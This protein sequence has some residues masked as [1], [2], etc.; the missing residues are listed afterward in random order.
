MPEFD[1]HR[2]GSSPIQVLKL[3]DRPG[4]HDLRE[5]AVTIECSWTNGA[6]SQGLP[7]ETLVRTVY[8]IAKDHPLDQIEELGLSLNDYF[9]MSHPALGQL[10][11]EL[12]ECLWRR[13]DVGGQPQHHAFA[14]VGEETRVARVIGRRD[15]TTVEAGMEQLRL[16]RAGTAGAPPFSTDVT[17][18]WRY[19]RPD[20]SFGLAA[21][22]V[23]Q[24]LLE[25]FVEH[26]VDDPSALLQAMADAV[27]QSLDDV[28]EITVRLQLRP[29]GLVDLSAM[30]L[31]NEQGIFAPHAGPTEEVQATRVRPLDEDEE[32]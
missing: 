3:I 23:R 26:P 6:A 28:A 22:G 31:T 25:T 14:R 21:Q 11:I 15:G 10:D 24:I 7:H 8:A 32:D 12:R 19:A 17:A 13:L 20:V 2:F 18:R 9:L 4:R 27:L 30:G 29:H 16:L 5:V 1:T